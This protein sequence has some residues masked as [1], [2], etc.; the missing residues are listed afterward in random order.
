M[1]ETSDADCVVLG[2]GVAGLS[3]AHALRKQGVDVRV[4][5]ARDRVGGRTFSGTLDGA[6]VDWGGEWI[7][8]GQPLVYALIEE[9]GLETF[10]TWDTGLKVLEVGGRRSTY[11]GLIPWMAPWKLAQI[12]LGIWWLDALARRLD[13]TTP[14]AHARAAEWDA[15]TLDDKRR[16]V[17][18]SADARATMDAAMRTIFGAESSEISL[19][20]ALAYIRSAGSLE[21]L[22]ATE[23]GFQHDRIR[24]G[25]QAITLALAAA[26]GHDR[27]HLERPAA[28][29]AQDAAGVSVTD[30]TGQVWRA[31]WVIVSV[32]VGLG[33]RIDWEPALPSARRELMARAP[34]GAAVK[35]FAR[36]ERA[37]WRERGLSGEAASG[38]GPISVTF[39][40]CAADGSTPCLLAFVG[41]AAPAPGASAT[42]TSARPWCSASS[43]ATSATRRA[44]RAPGPS[45]TGA[46]SRGAAEARSR[47]S[48]RARSRRTGRR[49][50]S[51]WAACTGPAPRRRGAAS[52]S[53]RAPSSR[54][55]VRPTRCSARA[56]A[57]PR[58]GGPRSRPSSGSV[59]RAARRSRAS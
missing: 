6:E 12:Q 10:P 27:V 8:E 56:V 45:T 53:S 25:A 33:A 28:R 18:W 51:P 29:V 21:K 1:R 32:P 50:A 36:Y 58:E 59:V 41:G 14:W 31:K 7:G 11:R 22:I 38:D 48:A 26:I 42:P 30:A 13:P 15:V 43:R 44:R 35:C 46:P 20:H 39:D 52:A 24:G 9:L 57:Q 3:A 40:Q 4:L 55:D 16:S 54:V 23:G 49:C 5:E 17:M 19:F 34:M 47:S 37:F 2:A